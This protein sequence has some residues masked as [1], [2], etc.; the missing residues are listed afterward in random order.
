VVG[1]PLA[2]KGTVTPLATIVG[3]GAVRRAAVRALDRTARWQVVG[4]PGR[5]L[6]ATRVAG[7]RLFSPAGMT[8]AFRPTLPGRDELRLTVCH[9][10]QVTSD[11]LTVTALPAHPLVPIDTVSTAIPGPGSATPA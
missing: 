3:R 11:Q 8:A 6:G 5:Q 2:L 1:A 4:E 10:G 7:S 9:G